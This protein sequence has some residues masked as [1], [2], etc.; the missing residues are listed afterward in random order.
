MQANPAPA[1]ILLA[2]LRESRRRARPP[3][4]ARSASGPRPGGGTSVAPDATRARRPPAGGAEIE[5][6]GVERDACHSLLPAAARRAWDTTGLVSYS[7]IPLLPR[8]EL[9]DGPAANSVSG[10][11]GLNHARLLNVRVASLVL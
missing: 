8:P 2:F 9:V 3:R 11:G 5:P 4:A 1:F 10:G 6:R 7:M